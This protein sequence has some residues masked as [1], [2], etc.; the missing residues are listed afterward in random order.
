MPLFA[1]DH[2]HKSKGGRREFYKEDRVERFQ[3]LIPMVVIT[4]LFVSLRV[5]ASDPKLRRWYGYILL[6]QFVL[7]CIVIGRGLTMR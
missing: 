6:I 2:G 1:L 3:G 7:L 5:R 4:I